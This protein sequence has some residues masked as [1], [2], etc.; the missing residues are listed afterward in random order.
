MLTVTGCRPRVVRRGS[1]R[2]VL[3]CTQCCQGS[4]CRWGGLRPAT[5]PQSLPQNYFAGLQLAARPFIWQLCVSWP[6]QLFWHNPHT[7][8]TSGTTRSILQA[9][10]SCLRPNYIATAHQMQPLASRQHSI[11]QRP[12]DEL[13]K[14]ANGTSG[15]SM[16]S[17]S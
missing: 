13:W 16:S 6:L 3:H 10:S 11:I 12:T 7:S 17:A 4:R 9:T 14:K 15:L 8:G 2:S 5:S 1:H